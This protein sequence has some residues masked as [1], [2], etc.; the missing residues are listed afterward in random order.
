MAK[1]H[2]GKSNRESI[3][4]I[5][6]RRSPCGARLLRTGSGRDAD[7]VRERDAK[8]RSAPEGSVLDPGTKS[9]IYTHGGHVNFVAFG[10]DAGTDAD[11]L[12]DVVE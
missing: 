6:H 10:V 4:H 12:A 1:R 3:I 7:R 8:Q 5:G 2:R 9:W 11:L